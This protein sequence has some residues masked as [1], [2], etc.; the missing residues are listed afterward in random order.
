M[1][2]SLK[3]IYT[4]VLHGAREERLERV[5][6]VALGVESLLQRVAEMLLV[7]HQELAGGAGPVHALKVESVI[8]INILRVI[9]PGG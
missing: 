8:T 7:V 2:F 3:A 5:Q 1:C 9:I 4:E 6:A